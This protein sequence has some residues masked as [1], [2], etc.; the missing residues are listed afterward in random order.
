MSDISKFIGQLLPDD[1]KRDA[2]HIAILPTIVAKGHSVGAGEYVK[3][4][5]GTQNE[6]MS[7]ARENAI[8]VV[9]PF[10]FK[11]ENDDTR[12][13]VWEGERIGVWLFPGTVTGMRHEWEHP[14][15][16]KSA[17]N[18]NNPSVAW[19]MEFAEKWNFDYEEMIEC[20]Q[21]KGG[22]VTAYGKD[23]HRASELD[24]G[25][26]EAFWLHIEQVTNKKFDDEHKENFG[27]S[28]SC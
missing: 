8:G 11:T 2:I 6:I 22:W 15:D 12:T 3:L 27:W 13:H 23:L 14:L 19:L 18:L 24:P 5:T 1:A 26:E 7:C 4:K 20:A 10:F 25:D 9:D 28:C 16:K 21:E 17:P